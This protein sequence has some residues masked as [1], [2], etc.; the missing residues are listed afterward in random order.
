MR[1][2]VVV[3]GAGQVSPLADS[4]DG[5]AAALRAGA[6]ALSP[7]D[8]FETAGLPCR[9][10]CEVRGFDPAATLGARNLR[11]IDR[12]GRLLLVAAA[13][14]LEASGLDAEAGRARGVGLALGTTFCSVRTI[15]E[16]DRRSL[17]LGPSHA[18]PLD[19]ANCV[20][21]AAA[22]Q[23]AIWHGLS[24]VNAT[25]AGGETSGLAAIAYAAL[26]IS[27]GRADVMLAGGVE[28]LSFESFLGHL[29]AG[30]L[31][32]ASDPQAGELPIPFD[33]KRNGF[34][35]G[36]G[37]AL[38]MLEAREAAAAR[39]APVLAELLGHGEAFDPSGTEEGLAA[40]VERAIAAALD[41]AGL[42][43]ADVDC[44]FASANGSVAGDRAEALGI[45]R[46]LGARAAELPVAAI[47]AM[48][49]EALGASGGLQAIGLLATLADGLLPGIRGLERVEA[50]FPLGGAT[51]ATRPVAA[52]R[53]LVTA[54][55]ADGHAAALLLGGREDVE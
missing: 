37:A 53:G 19:F 47:K 13:R 39:G 51:A 42:A 30:R 49:G 10:A 54:A 17:E 21:N 20:I 12:S 18:S 6:S 41:D 55:G 22:G 38:L 34:A 5:L 46:A 45:A 24:G 2:R 40:A 29:R 14:A 26:A 1:R 52:R 36:E 48:L 25:L 9:Q 44:V 43:P 27:A 23:A 7:I 3:T 28:E 16:F 33:A 35:L 32:G 50:G 31:C 4:T 8:L 15:A 11:P